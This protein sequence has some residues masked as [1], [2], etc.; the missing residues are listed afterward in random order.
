MKEE[1]KPLGRGRK[2]A[3][4]I[5]NSGRPVILIGKEAGREGERNRWGRKGRRKG[6]SERPIILVKGER[7]G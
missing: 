7:E 6:D 4:P 1:G 2:A 5:V 3:S